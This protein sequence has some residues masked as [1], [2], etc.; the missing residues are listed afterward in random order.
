MRIV[1][2]KH[3]KELGKFVALANLGWEEIL[4]RDG[5]PTLAALQPHAKH[6]G[7][8]KRINRKVAHGFPDIVLLSEV[9]ALYLPLWNRCPRTQWRQLHAYALV[10]RVF[11]SLQFLARDAGI[12]TVGAMHAGVLLQIDRRNGE[13]FRVRDPYEDFLA[14]LIGRDLSRVR[15]CCQCARIFIALRA[16]QAAC[17][18]RCANLFRVN[19]FR[20]RQPEYQQN[21]K[22]RKRTGLAPLRK[23]RHRTLA[24]HEALRSDPDIDSSP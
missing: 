18:T 7:L 17:N 4:R 11:D 5:F 19:K 8:L 24:L 12:A 21:R 22:F 2:R 20:K 16:D 23:G 13:T 14:A 15:F 3:Y 9:P 10:R 6:L 1:V